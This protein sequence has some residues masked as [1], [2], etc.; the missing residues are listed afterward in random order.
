MI[1]VGVF[2]AAVRWPFDELRTN[3][4]EGFL[5]LGIVVGGDFRFLPA[6]R[7]TGWGVGNAITRLCQ[8]C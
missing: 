8:N 2:G 1:V 3:G 5:V 7:M 4:L 6:V